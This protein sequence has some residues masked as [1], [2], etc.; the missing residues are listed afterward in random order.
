M[1]FFPQTF[2]MFL[3]LPQVPDEPA[4]FHFVSSTFNHC[5]SPIRTLA[6]FVYALVYCH[7]KSN[8]T[9]D[10]MVCVLALLKRISFVPLQKKNENPLGHIR[11]PEG[12]T[13]T[14]ARLSPSGHVPRKVYDFLKSEKQTLDVYRLP[15]NVTALEG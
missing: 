12:W 15:I 13:S 5:H 3:F 9:I 2:K 1:F 7:H 6:I 8:S 10:F 11:C 14:M 4:Y